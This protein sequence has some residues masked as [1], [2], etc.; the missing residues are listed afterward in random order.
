MCPLPNAQLSSQLP[1]HLSAQTSESIAR[2]VLHLQAGGAVAF[3]TETVWGLAARALSE[4]A[5]A[6]LRDWKGRGEDHPIAVLVSR[7]EALAGY[8]FELSELS[9]ALARRFW[10]GP[11][12][13]VL[14]CQGR[15]A[16][17][18]ARAGDGAVGVRC[19]SHPVA[20]RL[21]RESEAAGL[22]PLTATSLNRAGEAPARH[23]GEARE[24]CGA[25]PVF[26]I[27]CG[28]ADA[29]GEPPSTVLDATG[30]PPRVLRPGAIAS[31]D[32]AAFLAAAFP[33]EGALSG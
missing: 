7:S 32:L 3:P 26:V 1:A 19:S 10:P 2:A 28:E 18:I 13:L 29:F 6:Q 25:G 14:P 21:A 9:R 23:L 31:E 8:G 5:V 20:R 16:A 15:F 33:D 17:G 12:T 27:E 24:L 30:V 4:L 11:L 22:G